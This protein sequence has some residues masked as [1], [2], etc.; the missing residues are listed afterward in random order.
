MSDPVIDEFLNAQKKGTAKTYKTNLKLYMEYKNLNGQQLLDQKKSD[1]NYNVE[2][3]SF[4]KM[5]N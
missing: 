2:K 3:I 4:S 5:D 1:K